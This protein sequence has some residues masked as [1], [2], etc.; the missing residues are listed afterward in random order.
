M[1]QHSKIRNTEKP[2]PKRRYETELM[3]HRHLKQAQQ[4]V[5]TK[6][7]RALI[8]RLTREK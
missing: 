4:D 5:K 6:E 7:A 3:H 1:I 2:H 8:S